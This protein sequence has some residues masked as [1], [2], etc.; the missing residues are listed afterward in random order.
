[1]ESNPGLA[2]G[3]WELYQLSHQCLVEP[4]VALTKAFWLNIYDGKKKPRYKRSYKSS[5]SKRTTMVRDTFVRWRHNT[6]RRISFKSC[7]GIWIFFLFFSFLFFFVLQ[8]PYVRLLRTSLYIKEERVRGIHTGRYSYFSHRSLSRQVYSFE[9]TWRRGPALLSAS[10]GNQ[11]D[12]SFFFRI[13][14]SSLKTSQ[15]RE[16]LAEFKRSLFYSTDL[17]VQRGT[18]MHFKSDMTRQD[19]LLQ[20]SLC[21]WDHNQQHHRSGLCVHGN[22]TT[23]QSDQ[24][25]LMPTLNWII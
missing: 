18:P 23:E 19:S 10:T 1:M 25:V 12:C 8:L 3:K 20:K 4:I 14:S 6:F 5:S 13:W 7:E 16:P 24:C 17:N 11:H 22:S 2:P 15:R 9:R 21:L